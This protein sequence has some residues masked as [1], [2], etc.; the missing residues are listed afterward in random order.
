MTVERRP[1]RRERLDSTYDGNRKGMG[2]EHCH[3]SR[4]PGK[5]LGACQKLRPRKE[6][7]A[8]IVVRHLKALPGRGWERNAYHAAVSVS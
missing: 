6:A 3:S 4:T 7:D 8:N 5:G 1:Q 2:A